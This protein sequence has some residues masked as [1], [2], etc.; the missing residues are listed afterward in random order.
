[1]VLIL[2]LGV[3]VDDDRPGGAESM[4]SN[5]SYNTSHICDFLET[6]IRRK[7]FG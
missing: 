7:M 3:H 1:M 5:L 4:I 2:A 6:I